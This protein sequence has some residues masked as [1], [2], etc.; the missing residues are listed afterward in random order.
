M[1]DKEHQRENFFHMSPFHSSA[2]IHSGK[3]SPAAM[4]CH[5]HSTNKTT[6]DW[7]SL[8]LELQTDLFVK[9]DADGNGTLTK[10]EILILVESMNIK[11]TKAKIELLFAEADKNEDR[12][13]DRTEIAGFVAKAIKFERD[14]ESDS[15]H[16]AQQVVLGEN[17][18][19]DRFGRASSR[20]LIE[21]FAEQ[22]QLQCII[23]QRQ[24]VKAKSLAF[25]FSV[26]YILLQYALEVR[27]D[28]A[29]S[30]SF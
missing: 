20:A 16:R 19:I 9:A 8:E 30:D 10:E 27:A 11:I 5:Q 12:T 24:T 14:K 17:Q 7:S 18:L 2:E 26:G 13:L 6:L 22:A 3:I 29:G 28:Y 15:V 1:F 25:T 21:I 23:I 4:A